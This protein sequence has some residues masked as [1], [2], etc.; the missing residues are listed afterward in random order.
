[1]FVKLDKDDLIRLLTST[2]PSYEDMDTLEK[3]NLGRYCGG[4]NDHWEWNC[5]ELEKFPDDCLLILCGY[6]RGKVY[7]YMEEE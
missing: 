7:G 6:L 2:S 3:F 4:F 1:M 5:S